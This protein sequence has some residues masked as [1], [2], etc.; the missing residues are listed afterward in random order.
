M[1]RV[2]NLHDRSLYPYIPVT[3]ASGF[4][5]ILGDG[6]YRTIF[7]FDETG[8]SKNNIYFARLIGDDEVKWYTVPTTEL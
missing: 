1:F 3:Y 6:L 8:M 4:Y 2:Y 7:L 5:N